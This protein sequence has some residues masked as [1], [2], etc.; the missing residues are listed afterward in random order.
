MFNAWN[1]RWQAKRLGFRS[2]VLLL[3]DTEAVEFLDDFPQSRVVY[4]CVDD[5]RA[6]AATAW[7]AARVEREE[8]EILARAAAVAVTTEPLFER[9]SMLHPAVH[10]VPNAADVQ[11][12][13][14]APSHEPSDISGVPHPRIG[15]VGAL[16]TYKVDSA[17]LQKVIVAHPEWHFVFVG[18]IEYRAGHP[19]GFAS[20]I[21]RGS[22]GSTG[23]DVRAL[24][25][26]PNVHFLGP[27]PRGEVPAYVHAFDVAA[28]PYRDSRYNRSSFPLKFWEFVAS[29]KP[30]VVSGLPSLARYRSLIFMAR[31]PAEF[32]SAV[33]EALR[34]PRKGMADR[35][36][37]ARRHNW[38][39]RVDRIEQLL[40]LGLALGAPAE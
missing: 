25:A 9:F 1:V 22:R 17:L 39:G 5:H 28:I 35:V 37:E 40:V 10:L 8:A 27:K 32:A 13:L 11:A 29:G 36:A 6:S 30:V 15:T 12:F 4:D 24:G 38:N 18:P 33:H 34:D 20:R 31:T 2:P 23:G 3:Y 19:L 14:E 21:R 7:G 26:F 16:D